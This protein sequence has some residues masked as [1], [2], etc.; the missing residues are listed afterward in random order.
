MTELYEKVAKAMTVFTQYTEDGLAFHDEYRKHY[1]EK[2]VDDVITLLRKLRLSIPEKYRDDTQLKRFPVDIITSGRLYDY[3]G[4]AYS[5]FES[6]V[7]DFNY[8]EN[9]Y[10]LRY[11]SMTC[12]DLEMFLILY[13]ELYLDGDDSS[14]E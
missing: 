9:G 4:Q 6:L 5:V 10:A 12:Q 13:V 8:S 7:I 14:F 11:L 2:V 3:I 1:T